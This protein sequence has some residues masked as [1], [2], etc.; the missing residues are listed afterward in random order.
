MTGKRNSSKPV[1]VEFLTEGILNRTNT[2]L[3]TM[4]IWVS[5]DVGANELMALIDN[6][7]MENLVVFD[8]ITQADMRKPLCNFGSSFLMG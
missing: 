5:L 2:Q 8:V 7:F 1:L 4:S 3:T 6:A